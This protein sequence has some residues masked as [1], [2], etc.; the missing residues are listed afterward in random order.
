MSL[1]FN[2]KKYL[3]KEIVDKIVF[4]NHKQLMG[5]VGFLWFTTY[6]K[7]PKMLG[8]VPTI[9][10]VEGM[11][12]YIGG[13]QSKQH[14]DRLMEHMVRKRWAVG[15]Q[16]RRHV[17]F[18]HLKH[19]Y[20]YVIDQVLEKLK[21][22]VNENLA[23]L[24]HTLIVENQALVATL[25]KKPEHQLITL[26]DVEGK[27]AEQQT[28]VDF[29]ILM[30][31]NRDKLTQLCKMPGAAPSVATPLEM[32][33]GLANFVNGPNFEA[34]KKSI[35]D[36]KL[37]KNGAKRHITSTNK[38]SI[39][40]ALMGVAI[41]AVVAALTAGITIGL[42]IAMP[43]IAP[44]AIAAGTILISTIVPMLFRKVFMLAF[45]KHRIARQTH[46]QNKM[47]RELPEYHK[48]LESYGIHKEI[49]K[50]K[51]SSAP[52]NQADP[53]AEPLLNPAANQ[54]APEPIVP[55]MVYH[56]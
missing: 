49:E 27:F 14:V 29:V 13:H 4:R 26:A 38:A 33:H 48:L 40:A 19:A 12:N 8:T 1:S 32:H 44:L 5:L 47:R 31:T 15:L 7:M 50:N 23:L 46:Y 52:A 22:E 42:S 24:S 53:L 37:I 39:T 18:K 43:A 34:F 11:S 9:H 41:A 3:D 17:G 36:S 56:Y 55:S 45:E 28:A 35:K 21:K 30:N 20:R 6:S 54:P 25:L 10:Q 16:D 51:P 2:A